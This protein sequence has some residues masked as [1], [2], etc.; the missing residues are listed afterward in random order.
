MVKENFIRILLWAVFWPDVAV[1]AARVAGLFGIFVIFIMAAD[2]AS[3]QLPII[4]LPIQN[5][6]FPV[7]CTIWK[8]PRLML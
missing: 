2:R 8:A 3:I 5:D 7:G 6:A 1:C 4:S